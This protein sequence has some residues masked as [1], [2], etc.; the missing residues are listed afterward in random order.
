VKPLRKAATSL[1]RDRPTALQHYE[2]LEVKKMLS[3]PS[4]I[5]LI[6]DIVTRGATL[7]GA[8]NSLKKAFPR[9][10]INAFA[11]M[12]SISPPDIFREVYDP[13]KGIISLDGRSTFRR[14]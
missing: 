4:E 8:A 6:D 2:S 1:A 3:D 10:H 14:P 7:L 13:C 12:R 5:L 11:A 9:A